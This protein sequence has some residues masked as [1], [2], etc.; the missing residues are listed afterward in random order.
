MRRKMVKTIALILVM[1]FC[2][3]MTA[4][5]A[6]SPFPGTIITEAIAE[7]VKVIVETIKEVYREIIEY[8]KSQ[9]GFEDILSKVGI[10]YDKNLIVADVVEVRA[11]SINGGKVEYPIDITFTA[12]GVTP[13]TKGYVLHWQDDANA[14]EKVPTTMGN[15]TITSTFTSL[16][17]V[18]FI[19]DKTT[20]ES[21][22]ATSPQTSATAATGAAIIG[23]S[24]VAAAVGLKK[25]ED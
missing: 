6:P 25:K 22:T 9:A 1:V 13:S 3:G 7:G 4:S 21:G 10:P 14:W 15:G 17:P 18:A 12:K 2:F 23:L 5:A 8:L 16:S 19:L 24:A 20:L 11:E